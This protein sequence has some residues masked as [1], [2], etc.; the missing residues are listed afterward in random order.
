[1]NEKESTSTSELISRAL[2]D[3]CNALIGEVISMSQAIYSISSDMSGDERV[4]IQRRA[5][6]LAKLD[7]T[8]TLLN[9]E[10]FVVEY[11]SSKNESVQFLSIITGVLS[12]RFDKY[13]EMLLIEKP[14]LE[15]VGKTVM[16]EGED[17]S[18]SAVS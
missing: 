13:I 3:L 11:F 10:T 18:D 15:L 7:V 14:L 2:M 12:E 1:M 17:S 8:E 5:W 4:E 6:H 16:K 9:S